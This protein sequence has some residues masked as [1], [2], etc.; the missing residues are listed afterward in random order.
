[1][2]LSLIKVISQVFVSDES[3]P[4][5]VLSIID[6]FTLAK[7]C[8]EKKHNVVVKYD[9]HMIIYERERDPP[10]GLWA[11]ERERRERERDPPT[12]LSRLL[13]ELGRGVNADDSVSFPSSLCSICKRR[14]L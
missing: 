11:Y 4:F 7:W 6:I 8:Y 13:V 9:V 14:H 3:V 5:W 12:G 1:M 10:T 2:P